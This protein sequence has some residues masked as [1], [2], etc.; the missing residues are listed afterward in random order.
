MVGG[1]VAW[2]AAAL[3]IAVAAG[4]AGGYNS[5]DILRRRV[6]QF[7]DA[8]RWGRYFSAAEFVHTEARGEWLTAHRRWSDDDLRIADYEVVD[9]TEQDDGSTTIRVVVS[10]YRLSVSEIQT[11]MFAQ[12]WRRFGREWQLVGEEVEEGTPL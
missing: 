3:L 8:I 6:D 2:V 7:N 11:T 4:C 5:G 9:S 10:W 1:K 12:R